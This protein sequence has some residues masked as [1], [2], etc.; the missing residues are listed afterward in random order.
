MK[1]LFISLFIILIFGSAEAQNK[2]CL[3]YIKMHKYLNKSF[4]EFVVFKGAVFNKNKQFI[5]AIVVMMNPKK[6]NWTVLI[7]KN[8]LACV[9]ST[10]MYGDIPR[11]I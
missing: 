11:D 1:S 9:I 5:H 8:G 3:P 7:V 6:K 4:G 10:G 2:P